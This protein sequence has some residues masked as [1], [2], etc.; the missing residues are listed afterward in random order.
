MMEY[1]RSF[2]S[3]VLVEEEGSLAFYFIYSFYNNPKGKKNQ[4]R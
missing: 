3:S 1:V 2:H 4:V